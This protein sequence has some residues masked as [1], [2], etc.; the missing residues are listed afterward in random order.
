MKTEIVKRLF[1]E[2]HITFEEALILLQKEFYPYPYAWM[3][4]TTATYSSYVTN[5]PPFS[6]VIN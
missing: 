3:H 5:N 6:E 1:E 2:K 4:P